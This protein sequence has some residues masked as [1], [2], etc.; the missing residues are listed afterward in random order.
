MGQ[1]ASQIVWT[2]EQIKAE[3]Q[4]NDVWVVRGVIAIYNKQTDEEQ[5]VDETLENNGVGFSGCDANIL[6]SFARQIQRWVDTP[7][8]QRQYQH[9]L[10]PAQFAIARNKIKKY[11]GQLAKIAN[12]EI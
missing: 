5:S 7:V 3:L 9:P 6:S 2:K 8:N 11:S 10:S 4:T 1:V 12:G